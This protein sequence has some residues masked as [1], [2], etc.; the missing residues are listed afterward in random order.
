MAAYNDICH[1]KLNI[2][3][4]D[5]N[6]MAPN[7]EGNTPLSIALKRRNYLIVDYILKFCKETKCIPKLS[8]EDLSILL[9]DEKL[10][11]R[12]QHLLKLFEAPLGE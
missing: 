9:D 10:F 7:N 2:I 3:K 5:E 11:D 12:S 8:T 1:T 4:F 6:Q